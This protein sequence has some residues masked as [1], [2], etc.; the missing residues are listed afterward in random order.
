MARSMARAAL[1]NLMTTRTARTDTRQRSVASLA[2]E[3]ALLA[4]RRTRVGHQLTLLEQQHAAAA[5]TMGRL[6]ARM[7]WL[8]ERIDALDPDLRDPTPA[9]AP[10]APPPLAPAP[11]PALANRWTQAQSALL[12][13]PAARK[14][15][16]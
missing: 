8:V 9:P 2:S 14:W 6:L 4:Q 10:I 1:P 16:T 3:F 5:T 7:A 13:R 11:Q 12:S 15:R